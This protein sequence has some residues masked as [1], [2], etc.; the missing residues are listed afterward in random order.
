MRRSIKDKASMF[1]L[2]TSI[3]SYTGGSRQSNKARKEKHKDWKGK[4]KTMPVTNDNLFTQKILKNIQ[5]NY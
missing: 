1:T 3:Q 4:N 5:N 2:I